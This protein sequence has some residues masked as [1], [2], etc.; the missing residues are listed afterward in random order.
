[1]VKRLSALLML[2]IAVS[3]V[4][5][6]AQRY[7]KPVTAAESVYEM[8]G[9]SIVPPPGKNWFELERD[10]RYA[11]FGKKLDS[12]THSF[13]AIALSARLREKFDKPED[14]RDYVRE[15][16]ALGS[17]ER[18]AVIEIRA[19]PDGSPERYCVK[20]STKSE[21]RKALFAGGRALLVETTGVSCLHP[22]NRALSVDVSYTERGYPTEA[23]AELR[24]E[25]ESF[26]RSLKFISR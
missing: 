13:I 14:F 20:Y 8:D 6:R 18:S 3:V 23:S 2:A 1:V 24:A 19:E 16:L 15:M 17:N 26:V 22:D 7:A 9:Y 11:Y 25:G 5:A 10:E 12:R 4:D 21:D